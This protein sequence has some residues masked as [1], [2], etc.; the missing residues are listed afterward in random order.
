MAPGSDHD[1]LALAVAVGPI[2]VHK[3]KP[4]PES[5]LDVIRITISDDA[6]KELRFVRA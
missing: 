4:D 5:H 2:M 6:E 1:T 3:G